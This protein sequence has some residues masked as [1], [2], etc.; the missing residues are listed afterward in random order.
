MSPKI[1]RSSWSFWLLLFSIPC[2]GAYLDPCFA[3]IALR[4]AKLALRM[5]L[6][7]HFNN[8]PSLVKYWNVKQSEFSV[9]LLH[10]VAIL[11]SS[12]KYSTCCCRCSLSELKGYAGAGW[13][14][15]CGCCLLLS[16]CL[17]KNFQWKRHNLTVAAKELRFTRCNFAILFVRQKRQLQ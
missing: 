14:C 10:S 2:T 5:N 4:S 6:L 15:G 7:L 16:L 3:F 8:Q 1:I 17:S 13:F 12:I 9:Q 11:Q